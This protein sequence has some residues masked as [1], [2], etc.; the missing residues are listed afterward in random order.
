M[1]GDNLT[2]ACTYNVVLD[3]RER[4][5][6]CGVLRSADARGGLPKV[7]YLPGKGCNLNFPLRPPPHLRAKRA[8]QSFV[9]TRPRPCAMRMTSR[10]G[11]APK[12]GDAM[13]EV[14]G[15]MCH[16]ENVRMMTRG[17]ITYNTW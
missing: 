6:R 10:S 8:W 11:V 17:S 5:A 4:A 1:I 7:P 15:N 3:G 13:I 12:R 14:R 2:L 9:S 16:A